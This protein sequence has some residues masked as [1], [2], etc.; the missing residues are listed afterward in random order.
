MND[1]RLPDVRMIAEQR[2][3]ANRSGDREL[4]NR[5]QRELGA[6]GHG[7]AHLEDAVVRPFLLTG[8]RTRPI[9]DGLR[10]ESMIVTAPG[11][12]Y[13]P[14][15]FERRAIVRRCHQPCSLAEVA[16][17]LRLPLGVVT[18]LVAD[19]LDEGLLDQA[20]SDE[21]P[22]DVLERIRDCVR[23]L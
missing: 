22:I 1:Y 8:G 14:L 3:P 18:V 13:A 4:P 5:P 23:A 12:L 16:S 11:G 20:P 19:L 15:R 6:R 9:Q 17:S 2:N 7:A 21:L 10:V